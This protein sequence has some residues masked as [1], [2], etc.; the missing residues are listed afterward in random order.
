VLVGVIGVLWGRSLAS[1]SYR[2]PPTRL[3]SPGRKAILL[4]FSF[5]FSGLDIGGGN[6]TLSHSIDDD[7]PFTTQAD[8]PY[9]FSD[10]WVIASYVPDPSI[11]M[12][13]HYMA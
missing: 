12:N 4:Y 3:H 8:R 11:F 10:G 1:W 5:D 13:I 7:Y 6:S 9:S 2:C